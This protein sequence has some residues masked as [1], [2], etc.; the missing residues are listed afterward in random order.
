MIWSNLN[1]ANI[2]QR[3]TT[4]SAETARRHAL[5]HQKRNLVAVHQ[6]EN[7]LNIA[8]QW[9]RGSFEWQAAAEKVSMRTYQRCIDVLEGLIVAR[10]FELTKMNRSQTGMFLV[11]YMMIT[12]DSTAKGYSLRKHIANALKSRSVAIRTALDRYNAAALALVPPQQVLD[13]DQ[14]VEYAFLSDFDLLRDARQDIRR[15][16]WAT[17]AA[18][19]AIDKAFKLERA[20]EEILRL[21]IEV[22]RLATYIRDEDIYLRKKIIEMSHSQPTIAHQVGI[23]RMER[24][25]FNAHHLEVLGKIYILDGYTGPVGFGTHVALAEVLVVQDSEDPGGQAL[26]PAGAALSHEEDQ[27]EELEEEQAGEDEEVAVLTAVFTVL[28]VSLDVQCGQEE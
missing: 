22:P 7:K 20:E 12:T 2:D 8:Q 4:A 1:D 25:R 9:E 28:N 5:E 24:A 26:P 16:P 21:N 27:E 19:L 18:R 11:Y 17:P 6:L 14:V 15:K 23:H 3:D 10:M 13:W